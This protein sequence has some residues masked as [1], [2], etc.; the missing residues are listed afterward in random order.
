MCVYE[1]IARR[2]KNAVLVSLILV[3][4]CSAVFNFATPYMGNGVPGIAKHMFGFIYFYDLLI[5]VLLGYAII[6]AAHFV[7]QRVDRG[8]KQEES[9]IAQREREQV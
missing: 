7:K 8:R 3:L 5:F 1:L 9:K 4:L 6:K 2:K